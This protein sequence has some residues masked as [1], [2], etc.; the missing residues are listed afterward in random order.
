MSLKEKKKRKEKQKKKEKEK[1][2]LYILLHIYIYTY[3][4]NL[5]AMQIC[6]WIDSTIC[7]LTFY[8][9]IKNL[10]K[11]G[12]YLKLFLEK[13]AEFFSFVMLTG[14]IIHIA[15]TYLFFFLNL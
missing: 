2:K 6:Q 11:R 8:L 15:F 14:N 3:K 7:V 4:Q 10:L 12:L 9:I 5:K 1:K 13:F